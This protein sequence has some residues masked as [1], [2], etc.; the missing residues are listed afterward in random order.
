SGRSIQMVVV[1]PVTSTR[2][3]AIVT[4]GSRTSDTPH[5]TYFGKTSLGVV[6]SAGP[7]RPQAPA[8]PADGPPAHPVLDRR[9][10]PGRG[11]RR[12]ERAE[13]P[14]GGQ[15]PRRGGR[16]GPRRPRRLP[17]ASRPAARLPPRRAV[18]GPPP[19]PR[20]V[21]GTHGSRRELRH[22]QHRPRGPPPP[23]PGGAAP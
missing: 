2:T 10:G 4:S 19:L 21:D 14:H 1:V 7:H 13:H 20:A 6:T 15:A 5:I 9:A 12:A 11:D 22:R 18:G 23:R 16:A 8:G 17:A 3:S